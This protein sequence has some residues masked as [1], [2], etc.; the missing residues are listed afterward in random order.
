MQ[1]V[2]RCAEQL[3]S[4]RVRVDSSEHPAAP[5][6]HLDC[7]GLYAGRVERLSQAQMEQH[8]GAVGADLDA[9]SRL[10]KLRGLFEADRVDTEMPQGQQG[11]KPSD[12]RAHDH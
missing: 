9:G 8:T 10:P 11:S 1:R 5:T 4:A 2:V 7:N 3:L 6:A 12:A